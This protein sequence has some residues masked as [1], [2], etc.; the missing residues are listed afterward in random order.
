[1]KSVFITGSSGVG[2]TTTFYRLLGY[3]FQPSP[4]TISRQIR[5]GERE[6]VDAFYLNE[7]KFKENFMKNFFLE[8]SLDQTFYAGV[9]Y[10]CPRLWLGQLASADNPI[11]AIVPN[12][13]ILEDICNQLKIKNIRSNL[14]WCNLHADVDVRRTRLKKR[15]YDQ[16]VL[17]QR[18]H[19]GVSHGVQTEA[20]INIDT[21]KLNEQ[22]VIEEIDRKS[23]V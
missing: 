16:A 23:V 21:G 18:L 20:D 22:E 14:I 6:G 2:K 4:I 12:V 11:I 13:K 19:S 1:M 5:D 3:G 7:K 15:N 8:S 17:N 9:Y 10:G